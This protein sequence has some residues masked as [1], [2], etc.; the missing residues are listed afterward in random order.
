[1]GSKKQYWL[2]R[3]LKKIIITNFADKKNVICVEY[4]VISVL[5]KPIQ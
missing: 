3:I 5:E 4:Q 1:M 2:Y